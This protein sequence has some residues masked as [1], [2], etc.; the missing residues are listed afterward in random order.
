MRLNEFTQGVAEDIVSSGDATIELLELNIFKDLIGEHSL[1]NYDE[2]FAQSPEWQKVV[3]R[4]A[5]LAEKLHNAVIRLHNAGKK[6]SSQEARAITDT[7]YDGSDAYNDP[8]SAAMDLPRIYKQ[9]YNA[10]SQFIQNISKPNTNMHEQGVAEGLNEFAPPERGDG[11]E[12]RFNFIE[13]FESDDGKYVIELYRN[14]ESRSFAVSF[15]RDN[16]QY[17]MYPIDG[18]DA[19]D[20]ADGAD[21]YVKEIKKNAAHGSQED[22]VALGST[23]LEVFIPPEQGVA[24]GQPKEKEADYGDD[25]QDM[26]SRVK[27]LAGMGPLKTVYDPQK[28]VYK[29]VPVAVQPAQQPKKER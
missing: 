27:K 4:W 11:Q 20:L 22:F 18:I 24:E 28:R 10:I 6:I 16:M 25:Y 15:H 9:Q 19:G 23:D 3:A 21:R 26:V 14:V 29:N 7:A 1:S 12:N 5:P 13:E 8:A 17:V 2:E